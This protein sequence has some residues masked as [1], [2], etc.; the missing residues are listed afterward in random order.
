MMKS[1]EFTMVF[2]DFVLVSYCLV[3]FAFSTAISWAFYGDQAVLYL[4]GERAL[5]P[6]RCI[7]IFSFLGATVLD[8]TLIWHIGGI[9]VVLM[10]LPN[11][12]AM[13]ALRREV[14]LMKLDYMSPV[15]K[16][17]NL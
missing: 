16:D 1:T 9:C 5:V 10:T 3:L 17:Q 8:T 15:K 2:I 4:W 14:Q 12:Y 6:Y 11:L 7:Y 13:W